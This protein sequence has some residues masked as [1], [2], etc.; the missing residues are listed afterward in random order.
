MVGHADLE[1]EGVVYT[2]GCGLPSGCRS[3]SEVQLNRRIKKAKN[4]GLPFERF[5]F[6]LTQLQLNRLKKILTKKREPF[7]SEFDDSTRIAIKNCMKTL[8]RGRIA[9]I[10]DRTIKNSKI[11]FGLSCM[12][13]I[14]N[15]LHKAEILEIPQIIKLSPLLTSTYLHTKKF[16]GTKE[17]KNVTYYGNTFST[18][19]NFFIVNTC[20]LV[21]IGTVVFPIF[22]ILYVLYSYLL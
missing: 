22:A 4:G 7:L 14:S 8:L 18:A 15:V 11:P 6:H 16:W 1:F 12:H 5:S 3:Q 20:R 21:E 9:R 10:L 17:V 13:S 19:G 2:F